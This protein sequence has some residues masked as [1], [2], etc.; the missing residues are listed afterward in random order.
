MVGNANP[1]FRMGW[2][3]KIAWK[4]FLLSFL[5]DGRFGGKVLSQ[6]QADM[7]QF[8]VTRTTGQARDRG[9]VD[10]EGHRMTN[11]R[12]F[13]K[14]IVGGR[15]GVTEYYMYDATNIRLRE[16]SLG[17]DF[18]KTWLKKSRI[19]SNLQISMIARNLCFI[20][21]KAPFDPDLVLSTGNDNQAIDSYGMPT[22]RNIGVNLRF[23]F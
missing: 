21:K 16:L 3:N 9:Y 7:D 6:T 17:Y 1:R 2:D 11:V 12:E 20:Y 8:G 5:V 23:T 15:A 13:Y 10:L 4:G 14:S 22:T 18:P 19:V